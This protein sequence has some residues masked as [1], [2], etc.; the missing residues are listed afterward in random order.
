MDLAEA[1]KVN[2]TLTGLN[3]NANKI[4]VE[5]VN[6]LS[7]ALKVNKTLSYLDIGSN[8]IGDECKKVLKNLPRVKSG[9]LRLGI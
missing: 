8:E 4:G 2:K 1:L 5:G 6:A 7:E 3:F 9:Q